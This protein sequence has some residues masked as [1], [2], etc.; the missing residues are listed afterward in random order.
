MGVEVLPSRNPFE[1]GL[2]VLLVRRVCNAGPVSTVKALV[3]WTLAGQLA[4]AH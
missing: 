4:H 2:I 3:P 1:P